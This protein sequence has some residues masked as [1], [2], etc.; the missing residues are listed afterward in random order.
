LSI[1]NLYKSTEILLFK[2]VY[3]MEKIHGTS[4]HIQWKDNKVIFF[5]GG[6][7]HDRF[8]EL[9]DESFLEE[10][11]KELF[12]EMNV[13]IFGE[14][15]GGKQQGM[16][17]TYGKELK[18]IAFDV[19]VG[20]NWLDVPNAEDV[21]KKFNLEFVH[22]EKIP[23]QLFHIDRER[24]TESIQAIRNGCGKGKLREGI[25]LR[26]L[27]ELRKNN[28]DRIIVKHKRD[29]FM[30]TK[31]P[32]EVDPEKLKLLK[33]AEEIS[34]EWVTANRLEHVLDKIGN[35]TDISETG[36]VIKAMI[37]DVTREAE[38]E[39]VESKLALQSIGKRTAQL[40]KQK[41]SKI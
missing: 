15:Y 29:E 4:S 12:G 38:G 22:Y 37:E 26:P 28:G 1:K 6:E 3:A 9:F 27:I 25:V 18:F 14:A 20:D 7:K 35:P 39:I 34:N 13:T 5:S 33:D 19:K 30:E 23:A 21:T 36:K 2:E 16:S 10:K 40:F 31:T 11:F 17:H 8:V 41:I 32:R 24:D